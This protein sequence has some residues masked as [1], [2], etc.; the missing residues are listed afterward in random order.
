MEKLLWNYDSTNKAFYRDITYIASQTVNYSFATNLS[1]GSE[2]VIASGNNLNNT[3]YYMDNNGDRVQLSRTEAP[4]DDSVWIITASGN[5]YTIRNKGTNQY[6]GVTNNY[7][8]ASLSFNTQTV[9]T[10]SASSHQFTY[11]TTGWF[12][13]TYYLRYNN[14]F[15]LST[16]A[17]AVY[18]A[19]FSTS[20]TQAIDR[21][22]LVYDNA[23]KL[24]KTLGSVSL[25]T[26][27]STSTTGYA[28][29]NRSNGDVNITMNNGKVD[30]AIYG[31]ACE[32]GNIAGK[33]T[34]NINGGQLG[35]DSEN[36]GS[37]FGGGYGDIT[38][39]ANGV[40][41]NINDTRNVT[42]SG[43]IYGGSA[44]GTIIGDIDVD[45]IDATGNGTI[46]VTGDFY[47]GSMGDEDDSATGNIQGN[48]SITLD[49]GTYSGSVFGGNN[50]NGSPSGVVTVTTGGNNTTTINSV[51]AGGNQAD[52]K[53]TSA[54]LNIENNSAITNAFGGGNEAMVA[55]TNVNLHGGTVTNIY[56]GSNQSG[57][58]TTSNITTTGGTATNVYGGNNLGGT[59]TN[60]NITV[61][62]GTITNL[63]GGGN[64]ATTGTTTVNLNNGT[65]TNTYGGGNKAGVTTSTTINLD[66]S[67]CTDIF[68][69]SNTSGNVPVSYI[70]A[71]SGSASAIYGGNNIGGVTTTTNV[72]ISNITVGSVYGGGK[73]AT[74]GTDNVTI[75]SGN[76]T[77]VYGGGQSASVNVSTNV[78]VLGGNITNL[79]GGSNTSG[80]V[81]ES[82]VNVTTG[83][84]GT[85][86]GGNNAGGTTTTTN[87]VVT[88]GTI[89]NI[90]G[91]G[92][93]ANSTRTNVTLNNSIN[94]ISNIFG[95]CKEAN[96]TETNVTLNNGRATSVFGGSN[97]SGTITNSHV[98]VNNGTY[99]NLYGGNNDGGSTTTTDVKV[100]GGSVNFAFGGGNNAQTGTTNIL[101]DHA[102]ITNTLYG[103]GNNAAVLN[104]TNVIL[105]NSAAITNSA[106]AGGNNGPVNG[107]TNITVN[108]RADIG[109]HLYGGG[110][111]AEV[112]GDTN[113]IID[114]GVVRGNLFGG[115]NYGEVDGSTNVNIKNSVVLGSAYAGGNGAEADV[116]ENTTITVQGSSTITHHVFGGGNAADTGT[117]GSNNSNG[118]VNITGG[119]IGG[120]V[121]GGANTAVLYGETVVNIGYDAVVNYMNDNNYTRGNITIG[122]TVF[123]GG[124]ANEAGSETYDFDFISVT[125]GIIIN[126]DGNNH[127]VFDI[128][129]SIFGSGNASS[130]SGYSR[131]YINNYGTETDIKNNVSLQRADLA[132]LNNSHMAL[133]GATD[134]TNEYSQVEFSLSRITELDL[135]N[136]SSIYLDRGANLLT[137]FRSLKANGDLAEV[138]IDETTHT[139]D[140]KGT[141]NRLYILEDKVLNI[142]LNQNVT[143]YG[144]VDGMTFFGMFK[145][146]REGDIV[147]AMYDTGYTTGST[148][149]EGDLYYFNSGSYVLGLHETNHN[150]KV[151][152]F[153]TNYADPSTENH[154]KILV[155]YITPTPEA[156]EH[157]M[158][159]IGVS[160]QSY[161]IEMIA[162]KYSTLGTYEFPFINNATGNTTFNVVGFNYDEVD[163]NVSFV[164]PDY[165]PRIA[166]SGNDADNIMGIAI[167][168]GIGWVDV[169]STY[170]LTDPNNKWD[171]KGSYKSENSNITPSFV[172]Y[173]YHSKNLQTEGAMGTAIVSIEIITPIDDLT[174]HVERVNFNIT[175]SRA[176]FDTN[177]YE[178][179]MTPGREYEMFTSSKMDITAK[180]SLSAYYSLYVESNQNVYRPGYKHVL[181]SN[182]ILPVNT[183]I[184]MIDFATASK[185][186]YYYYIVNAADNASLGAD[187][188]INHEIEYPL[189]NFVRMGSI[190]G[191]NKYDDAVA[192]GI[193]Y[194]STNHRAIE[195]FIFI[196]DFKDANI[197]EN[198]LDCSLL[199]DMVDS[200]NSNNIVH[201]VLGIQRSNLVY[202]L[203]ANQN[204]VIDVSANLSKSILYAGDTEDLRVTINFNQNDNMSLNRIN[205]T[206]YF[207][208]KLELK[209][210][211]INERG[212]QVNGA[213]L[214]GTNLI[215]NG[216]S[217]YASSDGTYRFKVSDRVANSY[218]NIRINTDNSTLPAGNYTIKVEAFYSTDGIYFGREP[219]DV[220]TV[221]FRMMNKSYGLTV[222]IPY[223]EI[224]IDH[225]TGLNINK[226]RTI[227]A[228]IVY[229]GLLLEP[230]MKVALYRRSY[231]TVNNMNY[232]LVPITSYITNNVTMF[233]TNSNIYTIISEL[234]P[235]VGETI[236]PNTYTFNVGSDLTTGT[237]KLEFRLYDG[238][239]YVGNVVKYIIIK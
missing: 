127:S 160:V 176:I 85:I 201:S 30:G 183:K 7:F 220:T 175:I 149:R 46:S 159:T 195:E 77:N 143:A 65:V 133:S 153:Y 22:Y 33:V 202:S 147:T 228:S 21:F 229:S 111:A 225:A 207:D 35:K 155:D 238:D 190:D 72:D 230:N 6:L 136:S 187:Y 212:V 191:T 179:A 13:N 70:T 92:N 210:S 146:S 192:N 216:N 59:T 125:R 27:T 221:N 95:G 203:Y 51:Y 217:Y 104:D 93:A 226:T 137:K 232:S 36:N 89:T 45:S 44:L 116:G 73:Q 135:K 171:G 29:S 18:P 235:S 161:D 163:P 112:N 57:N 182:V 223:E 41:L 90:Y 158:W 194:D 2:Y 99:T 37:I 200:A 124:E 219:A 118:L 204:P 168:P 55:N 197:T 138:T 167:K 227:N 91:G 108:T 142:A 239:A 103:G 80:T 109:G 188:N 218:S 196:V 199:I 105:R 173:L 205:D 129:G 157:Y 128:H 234:T 3:V 132:V 209:I 120:N 17:S 170:F 148:A 144:E 186:E 28:V 213:D 76:I 164:N 79:F 180:S 162:S 58:I 152:G 222:D 206:T 48:C 178:G 224:I 231:A 40:D 47:C 87:V 26:F 165:V 82:H 166:Y 61:N 88:T 215:L 31:G 141:N 23:W 131:I 15:E 114:D 126:I 52:S 156:A 43:T 237:Y 123:G 198:M 10:W 185:P 19:T 9:W 115:G 106:F 4:S 56:G 62:G 211:I 107:D 177:D 189:S 110:N 113:L 100:Y 236:I 81:P 154:G 150:I 101:V 42:V 96:A 145:R 66:G 75:R 151:D 130:T 53:A 214:L 38:F 11:T 8:S 54:T 121:Y 20:S 78:D 16:T 174:N 117:S 14:G 60:S 67:T 97:T 86:Y 122:G 39:V 102:N 184:T 1:S 74:T 139:V 119:N 233:G 50:A 169:G 32:K 68:G 94:T 5:G 69:G 12:G 140:R 24:S 64:E 49:G 71:T 25:S 193:Y 63:Y 84:I 134:R 98:T 172:F 208:Q 34:I 181:T 83:T